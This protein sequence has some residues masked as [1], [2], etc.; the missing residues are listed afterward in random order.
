MPVR[1]VV[2]TGDAQFCQR[3][4]SQ[5]V[6][7][8][9]GSY[10]WVVKDNQPEL[11]AAIR[12]LF[13]APPPGEPPARHATRGQHGNRVERRVLLSSAALNDYLAWPGLQQVCRVERL[14]TVRGRTEREYSY[15]ITSLSPQ[16]AAPG[17]LLALWRDHWRIENQLH[18]VRD[19][20]FDEDRCQVRTG[21][22][23]QVLATLRNTVIGA[24]RRA[25]HR[26]IAAALRR[27]ATHP[28][29]ALALVGLTV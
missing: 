22:G 12:L 26:N 16:A 10:F 18:W 11:H 3:Q 6:L 7:G 19:V 24:L 15:A 27:H 28:H 5:Q 29:E 9:G 25:G 13:A 8:A 20:T 4:L 2:I 21:S 1:D 14:R 23:P 17:R